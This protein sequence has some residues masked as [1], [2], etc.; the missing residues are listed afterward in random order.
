MNTGMGSPILYYI[1]DPGFLKKGVPQI[2]MTPV[3]V[4]A[5]FL[6]LVGFPIK[7]VV[8]VMISSQI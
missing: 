7:L 1:R 5:I 2:N 8:V 6:G 4:Y 3:L